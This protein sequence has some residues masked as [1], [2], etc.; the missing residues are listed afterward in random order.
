MILIGPTAPR[1]AGALAIQVVLLVG[2]A[3]AGVSADEIDRM[4][5]VLQLEE[6]MD[7]ADVGAG[8]GEWVDALVER[9]GPKGHVWATE[10][11]ESDLAEIARRFDELGLDNITTVLG[12]QDDTGLP[13]SCCDAILL[14]MVY[15]HFVRPGRMRDSLYR[16]LR[17]G[18]GVWLSSTSFR[19]STGESSRMSR[20]GAVTGFHRT[21]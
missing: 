10:V 15:H 20:S 17:P 13:E 4:A 1:L 7:A 14:R 6:G 11:D 3:A 2:C 18:G 12:D 21:S 8:D 19:R 5:E 9:V 16:A